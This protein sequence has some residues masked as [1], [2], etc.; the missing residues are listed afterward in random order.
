MNLK[1]LK[2]H[3]EPDE[4]W[5]LFDKQAGKKRNYPGAKLFLIGTIK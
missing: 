3:Q 5:L 2:L 1:I 4:S